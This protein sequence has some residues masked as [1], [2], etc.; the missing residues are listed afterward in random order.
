MLD[1]F[2]FSESYN[3][4]TLFILQCFF[5]N[6]KT[7]RQKFGTISLNELVD[8]INMY[9]TSKN[10]MLCKENQVTINFYKEILTGMILSKNNNEL[11]DL[12]LGNGQSRK[13]K[14]N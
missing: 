5:N 10:S 9:D 3:N 11:V 4:P 6:L 7:F 8:F 2:V 12:I 13:L 1:L 14:R